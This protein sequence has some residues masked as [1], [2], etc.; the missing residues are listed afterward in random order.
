MRNSLFLLG[1]TPLWHI[2][3]WVY[4]VPPHHTLPAF[5]NLNGI[6][7]ILDKFNIHEKLRALISERSVQRTYS[8][9][10]LPK[11]CFGTD[12]FF[13]KIF[14]KFYNQFFLTLRRRSILGVN[15]PVAPD[16]AR[17]LKVKPDRYDNLAK[18]FLSAKNSFFSYKSD[19]NF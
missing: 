9:R 2:T 3:Q 1:V 10:N 8:I 12:Q 5:I 13:F 14:F 11:N 17:M 16:L 18:I 7:F 19:N 15:V 4:R 6:K